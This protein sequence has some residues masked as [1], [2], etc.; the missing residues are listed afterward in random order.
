MS[1]PG[2]GNV[3]LKRDNSRDDSQRRGNEGGIVLRARPV[4]ECQGVL[5]LPFNM[6]YT[7]AA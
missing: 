4:W 2:V 1:V 3:S 7:R 5:Y 6:A